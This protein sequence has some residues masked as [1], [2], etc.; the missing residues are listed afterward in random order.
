VAH[1]QFQGALNPKYS[2]RH[3]T[4]LPITGKTHPM[5]STYRDPPTTCVT[6]C[7]HRSG[8]K[9]FILRGLKDRIPRTNSPNAG[10]RLTM[11]LSR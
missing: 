10:E 11:I 5:L 1:F 2:C 3:G 7:V 8:P 4:F 9:N 6:E